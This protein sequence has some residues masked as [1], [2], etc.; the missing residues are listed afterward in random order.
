LYLLDKSKY[1]HLR[2]NKMVVVMKKY[3]KCLFVLLCWPSIAL[4]TSSA[5][6]Q[7][8]AASAS[9]PSVEAPLGEAFKVPGRIVKN[10]TRLYFYRQVDE[11]GVGAASLYINGAYQ[12]SLQRGGYT[13]I[14]L[15]QKKVEVAS[16]M[17]QNDQSFRQDF[18]VVN[19]LM[20]P[21]GQDI[22]V[23]VH[24]QPNGKAVMT[25][26]PPQTALPE[27][28]KTK[29]QQHTI[30]RVPSAVVC[31]EEPKQ[32]NKAITLGADALFKFGKSD[33]ESINPKGRKILDKLIAQIK[34]DITNPEELKLHIVGHT[35]PF[36]SELGNLKLSKSRADAIKTYFVQGGLREASITTDGRG[37]SELVAKDCSK[38]LS[39]EAIKCNEPNRR[40]VVNVAFT[41]PASTSN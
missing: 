24:D 40:V 41:Q 29:L 7:H 10:Q 5:S 30:S 17:V 18:D 8:D 9:T 3:F 36:G 35:D 15:Q 11:T 20:L 1:N 2:H 28:V 37:Y 19:T 22:M 4:W 27:L 26:T 34:T 13:A 38:K 31:E 14:C 32:A 16:R 6:A 33:I 39:A 21:P 23:R 12:A 25:L